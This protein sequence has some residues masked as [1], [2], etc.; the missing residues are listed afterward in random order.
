MKKSTIRIGLIVL[1]VVLS[2]YQS[3]SARELFGNAQIEKG[4]LAIVRSGE[5]LRVDPQEPAEI[6]KNDLLIAG[7]DSLVNWQVD[8]GTSLQLGSN[9]VLM[10]LVW[11]RAGSSGYLSLTYGIAKVRL[12]A[13]EGSCDSVVLKTPSGIIRLTGNAWV[14]VTSSGSTMVKALTGQAT[15][16]NLLGEAQS[17]AGNQLA[18]VV[19]GDL[20]FPDA[21]TSAKMQQLV[22]QDMLDMPGFS[23]QQASFLINEAKIV[24][25]GILTDDAVQ[26]SRGIDV[27]IE[28]SFDEQAEGSGSNQKDPPA[29]FPVSE[30]LAADLELQ[31]DLPSMDIDSETDELGI[32]HVLGEKPENVYSEFT[33]PITPGNH[34]D[35]DDKTTWSL[36]PG[37]IAVTI[38]K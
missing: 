33:K 30:D 19:N 1:L 6:R 20:I 8:Q 37:L 7:S 31:E 22:N 2:G 29:R 16:S 5:I 9:A 24:A 28:E 18:L 21:E 26:Q 10:L 23:D 35:L 12:N 11:K 34:F 25:T 17:L 13:G 27:S 15:I 3:A 36:E 14:Q 32:V 38:E 4:T